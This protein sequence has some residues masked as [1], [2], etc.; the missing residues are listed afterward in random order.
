VVYNANGGSGT[1]ANTTFTYGVAQ[2]LQTNTFTRTCYDFAGWA[3]SATGLVAY[4]NGQSVNNL[5]AGATV[6]LYAKWKLTLEMVSISG[7]T[8]TMGSPTTELGRSE[9][10]IQHQVTLTQGFYM[11]KYEVTQAQYQAVMGTNPSGFKTPVAPE[12]STVNRPVEMVSWYDAIVFCNKLS[13][14]EGL[15]PAYRINGNTDPT[16]WGTVPTSNN[17]TWDAV[18]IVASSTG[19]RLP[20]EAQWEYACRAGTT[21]AF[22]WGTNYI[23][24]SR[25]NYYASH[26]DANNTVAGTYLQRTTM[27][28]NY[29][30]NQW[31]LYDMHGNVYEWCW[32]WYGT[33]A[34]GAQTDPVGAVSGDGRIIRGGSWYIDGWCVRSAFRY[35]YK[36]PSLRNNSIG[37]RLVR[38]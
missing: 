14:E 31:G 32:D 22:N 5:T 6:T 12:T 2:N 23:S 7:G 36:S 20:T 38:P 24:S 33:Y 1:M 27:V 28:G 3:T 10:E 13:M 8:F 26:V 18:Q 11:G 19:Y 21:T 15:S 16:A 25:A 30:P 37:F 9:L 29:A 34:N 17:A 35:N 4:T